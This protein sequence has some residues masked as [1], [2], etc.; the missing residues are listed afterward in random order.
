MKSSAYYYGKIHCLSTGTIFSGRAWSSG[1]LR[2]CFRGLCWASEMKRWRGRWIGGYVD[3]GGKG[4]GWDCLTKPEVLCT[5]CRVRLFPIKTA[6]ATLSRS[7]LCFPQEWDRILKGLMIMSLFHLP[8]LLSL[9][10]QFNTDITPNEH[11]SIC[12][13][14]R[15]YLGS[16]FKSWPQH[17]TTILTHSLCI[18]LP[19]CLKCT[20][21]KY[22]TYTGAKSFT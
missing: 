21:S 20:Y 5:Y 16:V 13:G 17:V 1:G 14:Y 10:E 22:D 18:S 12:M 9:F 15:S 4:E 11:Q 6:W 19:L 7:K 2:K 8:T 3:G